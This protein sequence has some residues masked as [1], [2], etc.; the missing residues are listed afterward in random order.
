MSQRPFIGDWSLKALFVRSEV[1]YCLRSSRR[2]LGTPFRGAE[3]LHPKPLLAQIK[4]KGFILRTGNLY[5]LNHGKVDKFI[6]FIQLL[7]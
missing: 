4:I 2:Y 6:S 1:R 5:H 3:V 7:S